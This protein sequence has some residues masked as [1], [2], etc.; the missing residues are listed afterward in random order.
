MEEHTGEQKAESSDLKGFAPWLQQRLVAVFLEAMGFT[1]A[2]K[3][4]LWSW[5]N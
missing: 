2:G 5:R 4:Y 1:S 3:N